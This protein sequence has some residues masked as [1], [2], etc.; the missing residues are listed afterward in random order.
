MSSLIIRSRKIRLVATEKEVQC[1]ICGVFKS[2]L[3]AK[4]VR[5]FVVDNNQSLDR[6][7][8]EPCLVFD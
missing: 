4:N 3:I 5:R 2:C 8:F 6:L 1:V 7:L